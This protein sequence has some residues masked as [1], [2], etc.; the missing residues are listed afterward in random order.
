MNH[1]TQQMISTDAHSVT[2][3][4]NYKSNN[5][6]KL[7]LAFASLLL[8]QTHFAAELGASP[9]ATTSFP[10]NFPV[11]NADLVHGDRQLRQMLKD[12]P[13]MV[14]W[15]KPG[16]SIWRWTVRQFAGEGLG[17]RI[18]WSNELRLTING[19][20]TVLVSKIGKASTETK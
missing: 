3:F 9:A 14:K 1:A 17:Q 20:E 2:W 13:N 7:H 18:N 8:L 16:D 5:C 11:T 19:L 15:V 10:Q 4:R 6:M 12:R